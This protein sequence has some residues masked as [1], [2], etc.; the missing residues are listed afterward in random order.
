MVIHGIFHS[1]WDDGIDISTPATLDTETGEVIAEAA[2][3]ENLDILVREYFED[4]E[5]EEY[6]IC[7]EC[8]EFILKSVMKDGIGHSYN[9]VRVCSNLDC[10]NQ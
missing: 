4:E 7:P 8:H 9:E 1:I 3:I 5:G 6:E 10:G 2:D